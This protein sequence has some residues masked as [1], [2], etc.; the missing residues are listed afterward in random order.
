MIKKHLSALAPLMLIIVLSVLPVD[1]SKA[2]DNV[3]WSITAEPDWGSQAVFP[4]QSTKQAA[5]NKR[6]GR[7]YRIAENHKNYA[8]DPRQTT[9]Y[10]RYVYQINNTSGLDTSDPISIEF[11]PHYQQVELHQIRIIRDGNV[12]DQLKQ[13]ENIQLLQRETELD[14]GLYN[15]HQTLLLILD[16]QRV[17]DIVEY[18]YSKIGANPVFADHVF[19]WG[20]LQAGVPVG[21]YF[22]R[23]RFPEE[24]SVKTKM[25]AGSVPVVKNTEDGFEELTWENTNVPPSD[26]QS[27]VPSSFLA[28]TYVQY[29]DFS[30]WQD[31]ANWAKPL[32]SLPEQTHT[33]IR[34]KAAEFK[35]SN[36]DDLQS[37]VEKVITFVQDDI[38]YTG[39]NSGIGGYVPDA[40]SVILQRRFGDCKDKAMLITALLK[41]LGV[42]AHPALVHSYD[43]TEIS[44]YL[45]SPDAFN[46]MIVNLPFKNKTY[47]VDG[48]LSLQG[49]ALDTLAQGD[50]QAALV[51]A[52]APQGLQHYNTDQSDSTKKTILEEYKL[53]DN[54]KTRGTELVV[55]THLHGTEAESIRQTLQRRGIEDL[56]E[57]YLEFYE[58]RYDSIE[59]AAPMEVADDRRSNIITL[60]EKYTIDDAW[61]L[62]DE[63]TSKLQEFYIDLDGYS[64]YHAL[65]LPEDTRRKQPFA[66]NH[67]VNVEH[68]II[69]IDADGW[70]IPSGI[71]KID[72]DYFTYISEVSAAGNTLTLNYKLR[73]KKPVV[74][75]ADSKSYIKDLR[76]MRSDA[77]YQVTYTST[78]AYQNWQKLGDQLTNF[79]NWFSQTRELMEDQAHNQQE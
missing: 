15:G 76:A 44:S 23:I 32:F 8:R 66:Q 20:R 5:K 28:T 79:S 19:G 14:N 63:S 29:S 12:I 10:Q 24:K 31:V 72:N 73:S 70:E 77:N 11:D 4:A 21:N 27:D 38:R 43:G 64:V 7:Y 55:T 30:N 71:E 68:R 6:R 36:P 40:P 37:Q 3:H 65:Q 22:F 16:D 48:T 45:P 18:S 9:T 54:F 26:Y 41:E 25:Y 74:S 35:A 50:Y 52:L 2:S 59:L 34:S 61:Q 67:R 62:S 69:A 60:V 49:S 75:V 13:G 58:N 57:R 39:L 42:T 46:H 53:F 1:G 47:W 17:G 78:P 51:P 56:Q 33:L